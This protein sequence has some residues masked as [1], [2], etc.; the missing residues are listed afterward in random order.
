MSLVE[1]KKRTISLCV[2]SGRTLGEAGYP[3]V[4]YL[5]KINSLNPS[6][7]LK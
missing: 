1:E 4:W 6:Y 2:V 7:H 3:V 5:R